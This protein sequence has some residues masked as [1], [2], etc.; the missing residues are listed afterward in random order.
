MTCFLTLTTL[1]SYNSLAATKY[2]N[3]ATAGITGVYY[4]A[5][6]A[7]CRLVNRGRKEHA[8][9]C[10]VESTGGSV[11]NLNA[12]R[13]GIVEFGIFGSPNILVLIFSIFI[14]SIFKYDRFKIDW[15]N[16]VLAY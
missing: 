9:R 15:Y 16:F 6:G 1:F 2:I 11:A 8:I 7:I 14:F 10:S 13:S 5:G 4:P 12:I 3:V